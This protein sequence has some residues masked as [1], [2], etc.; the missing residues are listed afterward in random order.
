MQETIAQVL[1][2]AMHAN[3]FLRGKA[4]GDFWPDATFFGYCRSVAFLPGEPD[5]ERASAA[6]PAAWLDSLA[7]RR[8]VQV[9]VAPRGLPGFSDRMSVGFVDGGSRW[10]IEEKGGPRPLAWSASWSFADRAIDDG[11]IWAVTYRGLAADPSP[12]DRPDLDGVEERLRRS[13]EAAARFAERIGSSYSESFRRALDCLDSAD[14]FQSRY[15]P[16]LAPSG[17]L[18]AQAERVLAAC[19]SG[20]VFGGMG[21]WN[22]AAYGGADAEEGDALSDR[23][24]DA[25]ESG[26]QEVANSTAAALSS[27]PTGPSGR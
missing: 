14:A 27:S 23:L 17:F 5:P 9:R 24:F 16:D 26:L 10:L 15:H 3:A 1:G 2:L 11:R 18:S 22:D 8:S 20:W 6:D 7:G 25:L 19:D 13:L 4:I 21:S 12:M